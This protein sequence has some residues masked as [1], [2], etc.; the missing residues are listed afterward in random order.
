MDL[1]III[2]KS[3]ALIFEGSTPCL[4]ETTS[5]PYPE[6]GETT[7]NTAANLTGVYFDPTLPSTP[8]SSEYLFPSR[9]PRQKRLHF[10]LLS[11]GFHMPRPSG[12][13]L[14]HLPND[15]WSRVRIMKLTV[16]L[17]PPLSPYFIP[18]RSKYS[19]QHLLLK[20]GLSPCSPNVRILLSQP[21]K[22]RSFI[23]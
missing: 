6:L 2:T 20:K 19:P 17:L 4:Q 11:H 9:F 10:P 16:I 12:S 23:F 13:P 14:F 3:V 22:R 15:I 8:L 5:G 7:S 1:L 18:L 21:Y